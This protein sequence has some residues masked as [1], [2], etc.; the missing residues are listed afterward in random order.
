MRFPDADAAMPVG[1]TLESRIDFLWVSKGTRG[2]VMKATQLGNRTLGLV[3]DWKLDAMGA[4][5]ILRDS[6]TISTG[7]FQRFFS[8]VAAPTPLKTG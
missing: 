5:R 8:E 3:V 2:T 6:L 1:R 7:E 4:R